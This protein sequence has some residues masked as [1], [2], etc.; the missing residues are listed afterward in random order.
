[1]KFTVTKK[2][3]INELLMNKPEA[4]E[5][6]FK[7]GMSCVGCPMSSG[8]TIEQGCKAHGMNDKDID[9]LI[10]RINEEK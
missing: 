8:E 1:M 6:L 10:E 9:K 2:T 5:F 4:A 7:A 3:N